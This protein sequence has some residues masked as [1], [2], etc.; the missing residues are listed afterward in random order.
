MFIR[1]VVCKIQ[2]TSS[3][4]WERRVNG[5]NDRPRRRRQIQHQVPILIRMKEEA[6]QQIIK[7]VKEM[8]PEDRKTFV[9]EGIKVLEEEGSENALLLASDLRKHFVKH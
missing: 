1:V 9:Y 2:S 3:T 8:S 4:R 5:I 7:A 6:N